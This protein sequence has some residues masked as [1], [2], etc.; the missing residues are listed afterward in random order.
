MSPDHIRSILTQT[1][2]AL[3]IIEEHIGSPRAI[4]LHVLQLPKDWVILQY[5]H[6]HSCIPGECGR[7][8]PTRPIGHCHL[9][10]HSIFLCWKLSDPFPD[11]SQC[12][13]Q[14]LHRKSWGAIQQCVF[15]LLVWGIHLSRVLAPVGVHHRCTTA[16][17]SNLSIQSV[18]P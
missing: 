13:R 17:N 10:H 16:I 6:Y 12:V 1:M 4:H 9:Q 15:P 3:L 14:P 18:S 7:M 5:M 8:Q 2:V 11:I